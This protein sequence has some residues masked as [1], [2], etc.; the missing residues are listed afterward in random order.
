MCAS[1]CFFLFPGKGQE[2]VFGGAGG[3]DLVWERGGKTGEAGNCRGQKRGSGLSSP[4]IGKG[5]L[6]TSGSGSATDRYCHTHRLSGSTGCRSVF[7]PI[8][9]SRSR[10]SSEVTSIDVSSLSPS[11]SGYI[12]IHQGN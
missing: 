3:A 11:T 10:F 8:P 9:A 7:S 1:V 2:L 4:G 5:A 12:Y 6:G